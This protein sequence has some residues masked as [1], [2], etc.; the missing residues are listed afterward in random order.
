ME[1][2][3]NDLLVESFLQTANKKRDKNAFLKDGRVITFGESE[4]ML[5]RIA[6]GLKDVGVSHGDR[7][8]LCSENSV[9]LA[10]AYYAV[11]CVGAVAVPVNPDA[12]E[13]SL[14]KILEDCDPHL[15][16]VG[17]GCEGLNEQVT[18]K[19]LS[20]EPNIEKKV[21]D[22]DCNPEDAADILYTTG[23]T[24]KQKGV[25]LSHKN[26]YAAA[27]NINKVVENSPNDLELV[28][29]PLSHSFG[30]GRLRCMA[31]TG[32]TMQ[33][34]SGAR[35]VPLILKNLLE[36]KATG[37]SLVPIG[38]D[39]LR[40]MTGDKL[41][42]ASEH[43]RYIEIGSAPMKPSTRKW[44][45][46]TLPNTRI[47]HHYGLTEAS[48]TAFTK[49]HH[50]ERA[51]DVAGRP[52][53]AA[54]VRVIDDDGDLLPR[55]EVGELVVNGDMVMEGYWKKPSLNEEVFT[56]HGLKTG[57]IGFINEKS[58]IELVGRKDT[59][60]KVRGRKVSLRKIEKKANTFDGV[61]ESVC[62]VSK[63]DGGKSMLEVEVVEDKPI[64]KKGL[65]NF[66]RDELESF[67]VPERV[68]KVGG[69]PKTESGKI[70]RN[71]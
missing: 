65:K 67:E 43:L 66:L 35:N 13:S 44:L 17:S 60:V 28:P 4:R 56:E 3:N 46:E 24:G 18:L 22:P 26:I 58:Q 12:S 50:G 54:E 36:K 11:H 30:L 9:E 51:A 31:Q 37:L 57:D 42:E 2:S 59:I 63:N 71:K 49:Y 47:Y 8:I 1:H 52:S 14:T 34:V 27:T 21:L 64:D 32:N 68:V 5:A 40:E 45:T 53:P 15:L 19:E 62:R 55:G 29:I 25:V 10:V 23:T 70:I 7:V 48:R 20:T 69:I 61:K 41:G 38:F 16:I 39:I 33:L 6:S